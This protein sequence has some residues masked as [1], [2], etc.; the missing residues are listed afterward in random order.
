MIGPNT[1]PLALHASCQCSVNVPEGPPCTA[2]CNCRH[3]LNSLFLSTFSGVS[4]LGTQELKQLRHNH[5]SYDRGGGHNDTVGWQWQ[6]RLSRPAANV[7]RLP[8][9][10]QLKQVSSS[11]VGCVAHAL[12]AS[13]RDVEV[14]GSRVQ[15]QPLL[16][17]SLSPVLGI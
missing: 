9:A 17:A 5:G 12:N 14:R 11:R 1:S 3:V 15:D 7:V 2:C 6:Q 4:E 10:Q 13:T 16:P 8:A